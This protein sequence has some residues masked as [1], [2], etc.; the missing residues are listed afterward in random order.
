MIIAAFILGVLAAPAAAF[1]QYIAA[2]LTALYPYALPALAI[3]SLI[4]EIAK[5]L[6]IF[7]FIRSSVF[8]DEPVDFMI[9]MIT[10]GLG[11][12][13][14]ENFFFLTTAKS[15][16]ELIGLASLRFVGATLMHALT[17]GFIGYFWAKNKLSLGI[18]IAALFHAFFNYL[19]LNLEPIIYPTAL[20]ILAA[21]IL[22]NDF[23]RLKYYYEKPRR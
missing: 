15:L 7:I 14:A 23:D 16:E 4:E 3:N 2:N 17:A 20:L 19:I 10:A 21:V 8:F 6:I 11:F 12:A 1:I 22:F 5:F 13:T 9:Y 18:I